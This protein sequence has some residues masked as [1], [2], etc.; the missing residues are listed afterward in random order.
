MGVKTKGT[1][2]VCRQNNI[3][4]T[5]TERYKGKLNRDKKNEKYKSSFRG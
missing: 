4:I 1:K 3:S 5:Y 2:V